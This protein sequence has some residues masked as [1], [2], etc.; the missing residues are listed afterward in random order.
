MPAD[1]LRTDLVVRLDFEQ[2][3]TLKSLITDAQADEAEAAKHIVPALLK[4]ARDPLAPFSA[5]PAKN[6]PR[7][8]AEIDKWLEE[9]IRGGAWI[10]QSALDFKGDFEQFKAILGDI[11]VAA[12]N[13]ESLNRCGTPCCDYRPT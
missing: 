2:D 13:H 5:K 3:G 7:L 10:A 8:F 6:G 12:I 9:Q 11:P 1:T 4:A